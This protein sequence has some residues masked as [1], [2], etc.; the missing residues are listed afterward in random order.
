MIDELI[1]RLRRTWPADCKERFGLVNPDGPEAAA[2]LAQQA[3]RIAALEGALQE[4][5][6]DGERWARM[7][8][9]DALSPE[10]I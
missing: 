6:R 10:A 9:T 5:R 4:I 8:A 2:A 3:E 1:A 7:I